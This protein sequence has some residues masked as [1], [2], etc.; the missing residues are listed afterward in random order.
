M[1]AKITQSRISIVK[2]NQYFDQKTRD[3]F[4]L[5][6]NSPNSKLCYKYQEEKKSGGLSQIS[7]SKFF[8]E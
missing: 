3:W 5:A 8:E 4:I 2:D 6:E 7:K 1:A